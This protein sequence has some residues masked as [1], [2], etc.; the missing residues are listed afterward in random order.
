MAVT[1]WKKLDFLKFDGGCFSKCALPIPGATL[2]NEPSKFD[3]L[4][5]KE[6]LLMW[7][8][9]RIF[10]RV[11]A[12][13][14]T[15]KQSVIQLTTLW[16]TSLGGNSAQSSNFDEELVLDAAPAMMGN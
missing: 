3:L 4:R 1:K 10:C 5:R 11:V 13:K 6:A 16:Q 15:V 2:K 12:A 8:L 14:L 9:H 7:E